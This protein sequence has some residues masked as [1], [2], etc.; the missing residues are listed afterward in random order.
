MKDVP[1][2]VAE[3]DGLVLNDERR[4][5]RVRTI[6]AALAA[7]PCATFPQAM[8]SIAAREGFY[9][10][11][12]NEAVDLKALIS[13]HAEHTVARMRRQAGRPIVAIDKTQFV[14]E[15]EDERDGLERLTDNTQALTAFFALAT[16]PSKQTH[17]VLAVKPLDGQGASSAEE[18]LAFVEEAGRGAEAAKLAPI[19]V[20]DRE[21]D[22]YILFCG[23]SDQRRDFVVRVSWDRL[24]KELKGKLVEPFRDV[25]AR[26]P[27][28]LT[29]EVQLSRRTGGGKTANQKKKHP[30]RSTR[31]TELVVRACTIT[32]PCPSNLRRLQL[33]SELHLQL[34]H[35]SEGTAPA[36]QPP[37][38]WF[39]V[40]SLPIGD[41]ASV[42]AIVDAYRARWPIEEYFKALKTGCAYEQRQLESKH[43]LLNALGLLIPI[44]WRLLELRTLSED[45]PDAPASEVLEPDELQV[46][47]TLSR[48]VKL[49]PAPTIAEAH[50]AIAS[51]GGHI[52]QNGRPGWQVLYRGWRKLSSYVAGYRIKVEM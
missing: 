37:V 27:I 25:A 6:L 41:A 23:L 31:K 44:A 46:L 9:R 7:D 17:G 26:A 3:F 47:R 13:P 36:G 15:G 8:G 18:W 11:I 10:L 1:G 29:R 49:G 20:M 50:L 33:P 22:A 51:I 12:N 35:V 48:D 21:A 14:F 2:A 28:V 43:S 5:A 42:E 16:T 38:E 39:L 19:Y 4:V 32:M 40:T 34:V 52:K 24:V 45:T 30:P